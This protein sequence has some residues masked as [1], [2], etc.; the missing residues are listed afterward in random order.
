MAQAEGGVT[1][2]HDCGVDA[3]SDA[4]GFLFGGALWDTP[5]APCLHPAARSTTPAWPSAGAVNGN[6][7]P[8]SPDERNVLGPCVGSVGADLCAPTRSLSN[9]AQLRLG[10]VDVRLSRAG[11]AQLARV[12]RLADLGAT[13]VH[14]ELRRLGELLGAWAEE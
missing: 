11:A 8:A 6:P 12:I 3:A 5:L 7:A 10:A 4:G 9:A 13:S 14:L 2:P 1:T